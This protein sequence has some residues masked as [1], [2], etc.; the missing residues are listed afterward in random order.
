VRLRLTLRA[1]ADLQ[2]IAAYLNARNPQAALR[3]EGELR[4][5]FALLAAHPGAGPLRGGGVRRFALPRYP[6][7]IFFRVDLKD[8]AISILTIR[9][10][11][12]REHRPG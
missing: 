9:H 3:V 4:A 2:G 5:A 10:A 8:E 11:A 7:L 6:Y 12:R 1:E